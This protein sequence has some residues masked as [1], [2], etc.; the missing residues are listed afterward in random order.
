MVKPTQLLSD[1]LKEFVYW[2]V[3]FGNC[4]SGNNCSYV[5]VDY[6]LGV[7]SYYYLDDRDRPYFNQVKLNKLGFAPKAFCRFKCGIYYCYLTE[8]VETIYST[9]DPVEKTMYSIPS[10]IE[11]I[12]Q[13]NIEIYDDIEENFGVKDGNLLLIDCE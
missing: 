12:K 13:Y 9:L 7:K 4:K 8:H 3:K 6:D 10:L 2:S 11:S 1:N 5:R